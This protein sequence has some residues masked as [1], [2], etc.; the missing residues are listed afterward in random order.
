MFLFVSRSVSQHGGLRRAAERSGVGLPEQQPSYRE[1][2]GETCKSSPQ[3]LRHKCWPLN[4]ETLVDAIHAS[5]VVD[6]CSHSCCC[7]SCQSNVCQS[8]SGF[9]GAL[10]QFKQ[11]HG[12]QYSSAAAFDQL[13]P[14]RTK[15]WVNRQYPNLTQKATHHW[16]FPWLCEI[17]GV[18]CFTLWI[19]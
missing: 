5:A 1:R 7:S 16:S 8:K 9:K 15:A 13:L 17:F 11:L 3:I 14:N 18:T 10:L 19:T 6:R 12:E 2:R 4:N